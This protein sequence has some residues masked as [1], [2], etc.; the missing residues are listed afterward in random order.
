MLT[1]QK[2]FWQD[3]Y[4]G[5]TKQKLIEIHQ[6]NPKAF[7]SEKSCMLEY[8]S[9]YEHL[10]DVL[11]DKWTAFTDWFNG[12]TSPE[13]ISRARRSLKEEWRNNHDNTS[14]EE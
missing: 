6:S 2:G 14:V 7:T 5:A 1:V 8:W 9:I 10:S 12:C 4:L 3:E 13:T 11:G